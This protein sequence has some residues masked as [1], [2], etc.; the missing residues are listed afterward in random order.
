MVKLN[1]K[2]RVAQYGQWDGYPT[3]QGENIAAFVQGYLVDDSTRAL[4]CER[5]EAT[6]FGTAKQIKA[7]YA[8]WEALETK[9]AKGEYL[10]KH[11]LAEFAPFERDTGS[12]ILAIINRNYGFPA[13]LG[14]IVLKN[15]RAFLKDSLMCEWAYCVNL[16]KQVVEVYM[17]TQ[18]PLATIPFAQFTVASMEA[19]ENELRKKSPW[20][21][22]DDATN[23]AA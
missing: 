2:I 9:Q 12:N 7:K 17:A 22:A 5:V 20:Y 14:G 23:D 3:G 21:V 19:L 13:I 8:E 11:K 1:G 4:F 15:D 10:P 16:D 18:K 6:K